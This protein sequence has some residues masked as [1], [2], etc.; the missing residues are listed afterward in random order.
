MEFTKLWVPFAI[1]T[2]VYY[3]GIAATAM[4][5]HFDGAS[6]PGGRALLWT[7]PGYTFLLP[8]TIAY[9]PVVCSDVF[10]MAAKAQGYPNM[11]NIH[12]GFYLVFALVCVSLGIFST[13]WLV[14]M[15]PAGLVAQLDYDFW[16]LYVLAATSV[17]FLFQIIPM[18]ANSVKHESTQEHLLSPECDSPLV[19]QTSGDP[20]LAE[21]V[22]EFSSERLVRLPLSLWE[23]CVSLL[24][25]GRVIIRNWDY[26][27]A[28]RPLPALLAAF[29]FFNMFSLMGTE[30]RITESYTVVCLQ[31]LHLIG[32]APLWL[33]ALGWR[34]CADEQMVIK[35]A[36]GGKSIGSGLVF[37]TSDLLD[38]VVCGCPASKSYLATEERLLKTAA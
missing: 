13:L 10:K 28:S 25:S 5:F 21:Q 33:Q 22:A 23:L 29:I 31:I 35:A 2:T 4:F 6:L 17:L 18:F 11:M 34:T 16:P 1:A 38:A 19:P 9:S 12:T 7:L 37:S 26:Y 20:G 15:G 30:L 36:E 3:V 24:Q 8:R 14:W 32:T 27:T